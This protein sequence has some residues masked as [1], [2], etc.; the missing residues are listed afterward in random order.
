MARTHS[1]ADPP[2]SKAANPTAPL[3]GTVL[4]GA[5]LLLALSMAMHEVHAFGQQPPAAGPTAPAAC[6]L[7][8]Q[9]ASGGTPLPGV[10]VVARRGDRVVAA[11]STGVDGA[12]G[13]MLPGSQTYRL[14][15][16]FMGFAA[17]H[18]D[19][20]LA[21]ALCDASLDFE[22]ALA[23]RTLNA[24]P[25][26]SPPAVLSAGDTA[27]TPRAGSAPVAEPAATRRISRGGGPGR[28]FEALDVELEGILAGDLDLIPEDSGDPATQ[29][30]LPPG[31]STNGATDAVAIQGETT[32]LDSGMMRDRLLALGRGEFAAAGATLPDGMLRGRPG[33]FGGRGPFGDLTAQGFG[34]GQG[35]GPGP[36]RGG[37][38][39]FLG[40]RLR[41]Q[42]RYQGSTTY[43]FG[44]S[45]L[46]AEPYALRAG[47]ETRPDYVRQQYGSTVGGPLPIPGVYDG[48]RT[49]FFLSV[50]GNRSTDLVDQYAT[51]PTT[52][53]RQGDFS[54]SHAAV[55]DPLTEQPFPDNRIPVDRLDPGARSL[56]RFLPEPNL[57]GAAQNFQ[58]SRTSQSTADA[59]SL[60]ITQNFS[61]ETGAVGGR[62]GRGGG[63][64]PGA[65]GGRGGRG[66]SIVLNGQI[67][68]RRNDATRLG[69]FSTVD[70]TR[71][72][73]S[74][75]AP[76]T[77]N[78][79]KGRMM[80][81]IRATFSQTR[82]DTVNQY[83]GI[84]NVAA[85]AG[86]VGVAADPFAWGVPDL[87]FSSFT[88]LRDVTPSLRSDRRLRVGYTATRPTGRHRIR[89]G[90]EIS[91]D[92]SS[93][94]TD[95]SARGSFVFTG[96]YTG[97]G[98]RAGPGSGLDFADFLLGLPQQA[99]VQYGPGLVQLRGQSVSLF[100]QDNWRKSAGLT[101]NLGVRYELVKPFT[102]AIGRM[103]GLDVTPD[104]T[105]AAP[106]LAG[107]DGAF[108]G[109][110]P[111]ALVRTDTNNIAPRIGVAWRA[112]RG[113]VVR[114]GYGVSFNSGSYGSIARQ[115]VAQ[116]PFAVTN[117]TIGTT[118]VPLS[119]STPFGDASPDTTT[120][121]YGI[122]KNYQ[123]G[124]V[125]TW[126]LDIDRNLVR[127]WSV[128]GGYTGTKGSHLDLLRAPNRGP[129][130]LRI[131]GVQ[132]FLWQSSGGTSLLHAGTLRLRKR[133]AGGIGGSLRYTLAR[134]ID[135][136]SSVGG[137]A[138]VVAQDDQNLEAERGL[139]SFDRRHQL[140]A[141]ILVEF[142]F[143]ADHRWL[144]DGGLLA[145]VLGDWSL[146]AGITAQSGTPFTARIVGSPTE[147]ARGTSG[148]LRADVTGAPVAL[149]NPTL[150]Q[151]FNTD[152][153]AVPAPGAFGTAGRNTVIGP[154]SRQLDARLTRIIRVG[155]TQTVRLSLTA[156]NLL[157]TVQYAAIDAVVTSPTFGEVVAVRPMRS[158]R[159][160]LRFAY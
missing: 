72:G 76:V 124:V 100:V 157:N 10:A 19:L 130:G 127:G 37:R 22:L 91:Q 33:G 36:G 94:Q 108:S 1:P 159:L 113:T 140:S 141:D 135:N 18:R 65:R 5:A 13:L 123:L 7:S 57:P 102:E 84:E 144:N 156:N 73:S 109:V 11:T 43:T 31:F 20:A 74:F 44:G 52:A 103:V 29:L 58:A 95:T 129:D 125:Q 61:A 3:L 115:L 126:N 60:R 150:L 143:G 30:L 82:S 147:V 114:T 90:G 99:A 145:A 154:G 97:A 62:G 34:P 112:T 54:G 146:T 160:D 111:G 4:L 133:L 26:D 81:N 155:N 24:T 69:A 50:Q 28:R 118:A 132:P 6:R 40:R 75:T 63:F 55:V 87:S 138:G 117:T 152:A 38:G 88:S 104:F 32:R 80:H 142:P 93:S 39:G 149:D 85:L 134:S 151:Y 92:W 158:V 120:N 101:L 45:A 56:L 21:P 59:V 105:A 16:A 9:I 2:L 35:L 42:N 128:G 71:S 153:F 64:G 53:V 96:L 137:G 25:G 68:Y 121:N 139:S 98:N 46:D 27:P 116:P 110:F 17:V 66:T 106:V 15:T 89:F 136:A 122:D 83:A 51:V 49:T 107:A 23:S 86:I 14:S 148:T 41:G 48:S 131:A 79:F 8:G 77:L 78:V 119:L 70:G 47:A 12:W 67:Q